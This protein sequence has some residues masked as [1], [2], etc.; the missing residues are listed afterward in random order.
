M[1]TLILSPRFVDRDMF[2]RYFGGAPGHVR[3][4]L[5]YPQPDRP[6]ARTSPR[7]L[8]NE[9]EYETTARE[10]RRARRQRQ[11]ATVDDEED[12]FGYAGSDWE[13]DDD[14]VALAEEGLSVDEIMY[15]R[16]G[17]SKA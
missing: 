11:H 7:A 12:D 4:D 9:M 13:D 3:P 10:E 8:Q 2:M 14:E 16:S 5:G 17:M 15:L 1:A 6:A